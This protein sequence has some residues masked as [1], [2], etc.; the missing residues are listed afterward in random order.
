V[1]FRV[2]GRRRPVADRA[3]GGRQQPDP[4]ELERGA[5]AQCR[6]LGHH[7]C[8]ARRL[9]LQAADRLLLVPGPA[10]HQRDDPRPRHGRGVPAAV[11]PA[12][13]DPGGERRRVR[14]RELG[15]RPRPD[16]RRGLALH[17]REQGVPLL[18]PEPRRH[19]QPVPRQR[20][21]GLRRG[22]LRDP[23][24]ATSTA[25]AT[26]PRSSPRCQARSR[27]TRARGGTGA[28]RSTTGSTTR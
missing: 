12:R 5:A 8:G 2:R 25:T 27:P 17:R 15:D 24:R 4:L 21:R 22:I 11:H 19:G 16:L 23:T 10:L 1:G 14:Q 7:P 28:R 20:R 9:L 6:V 13:R 18:P 3:V 26:P